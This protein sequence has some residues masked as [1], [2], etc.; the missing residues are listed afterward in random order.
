MAEMLK[1]MQASKTDRRLLI[2]YLPSGL[3]SAAVVWVAAKPFDG[4]GA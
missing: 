2:R 4:S 1:Q 3:R